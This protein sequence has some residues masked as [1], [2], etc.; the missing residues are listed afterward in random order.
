LLRR[1]FLRDGE[2]HDEAMWTILRDEWRGA[3]A[4]WGAP[5]VLH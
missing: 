2:F 3:K 1:S 4:T 5:V